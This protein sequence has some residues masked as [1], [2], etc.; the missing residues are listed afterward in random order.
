MIPDFVWL[1]VMLVELILAALAWLILA[2]VTAVRLRSWDRAFSE[3][4]EELKQEHEE[5]HEEEKEVDLRD[6]LFC[7]KS[8]S[9]VALDGTEIL[10]CFDCKGYEGK[11]VHAD[12]PC[13]NY[14]EMTYDET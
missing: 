4:L 14:E 13:D 8:L 7:K 6:C 10:I 12:H 2:V 1:L 3:M 9:E 5:E 11:G